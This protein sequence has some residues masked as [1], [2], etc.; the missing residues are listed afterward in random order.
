MTY[1]QRIKQ[2]N[3]KRSRVAVKRAIATSGYTQRDAAKELGVPLSS[4]SKWL[5]GKQGMADG[6]VFRLAEWAGL[7]VSV[8]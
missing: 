7:E 2:L 4:L 3:S 1:T 6:R 5:N 8:S